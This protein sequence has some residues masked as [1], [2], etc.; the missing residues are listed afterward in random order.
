M[1]GLLSGYSARVRIVDHVS[2]FQAVR[3]CLRVD[4]RLAI[5]VPQSVEMMMEDSMREALRR[6]SM[7]PSEVAICSGILQSD[8]RGRVSFRVDRITRRRSS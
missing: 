2:A 8:E 1:E 3:S 6:R 7:E 5:L 4:E